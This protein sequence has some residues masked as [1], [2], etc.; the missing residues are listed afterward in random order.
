MANAAKAAGITVITIGYGAAN[1]T[2]CARR[3]ASSDPVA[4]NTGS[5]WTRNYLAA[6]SGEANS[7]TV[8]TA[9]DCGN[10]TGLATENSDGDNYFCAA[11]AADLAGIFASAMGAISG[12]T[13]LISI[14]NV[15]N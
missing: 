9:T 6:A 8:A 3:Y 5:K 10:A 14:P 13:R 1:G 4:D 12:N 7:T 2:T 15:S 11:S